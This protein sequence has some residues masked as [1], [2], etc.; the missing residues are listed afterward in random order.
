MTSKSTDLIKSA[1]VTENNALLIHKIY[2]PKNSPKMDD[3]VISVRRL[4]GIPS[5][6]IP[7]KSV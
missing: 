7:H 1:L 6:H 4:S 2:F 5:T 3:L